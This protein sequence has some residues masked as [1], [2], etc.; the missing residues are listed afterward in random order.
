[1]EETDEDEDEDE[2]EEVFVA[3]LSL[4]ERGGDPG[5]PKTRP[6]A[7][8][9]GAA[10]DDGFEDEEEDDEEFVEEKEPVR[11]NEVG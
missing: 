4:R 9:C 10:G 7:G 3:P 6:D 5:G 8:G 11:L 1:M 2:V